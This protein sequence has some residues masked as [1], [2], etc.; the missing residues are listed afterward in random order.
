MS[1]FEHAKMPR[2]SEF[3]VKN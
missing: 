2:Y 1:Y 3:V